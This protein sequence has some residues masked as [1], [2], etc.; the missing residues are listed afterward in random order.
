[1]RDLLIPVCK[2][3]ADNLNIPNAGDK[4]VPAT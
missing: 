1:M 2:N 4:A 3:L